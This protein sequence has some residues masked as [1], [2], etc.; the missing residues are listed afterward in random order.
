M[1]ARD[2]E[3]DMKAAVGGASFITPGQL[4]K[5]LGQKNTTRAY[6]RKRLLIQ[7]AEDKKEIMAEIKVG[8]VLD[9]A[10]DEGKKFVYILHNGTSIG[11]VTPADT[12]PIATSLKLGRMMYAI[13]TEIKGNEIECEGWTKA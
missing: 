12:L 9:F 13:V 4:A 1:T 8:T 5:Y 10:L 2:I 7:I 6:Y 3:N 11:Q